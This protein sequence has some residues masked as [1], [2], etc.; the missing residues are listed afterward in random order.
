VNRQT[1][2]VERYKRL[3]S[4]VQEALVAIGVK[5]AGYREIIGVV[6]VAKEA[7]GSWGSFLQHLKTRGLS[8]VQLS[9]TD[10]G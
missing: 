4:F 7:R 5:S 9:I 3:E 6:E 8:E 1:A 10:K 2:I